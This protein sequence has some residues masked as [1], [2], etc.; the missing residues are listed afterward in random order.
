MAAKGIEVKD[1][2]PDCKII[3]GVLDGVKQS[4]ID[5]GVDL[6]VLSML[7]ELWVTKLRYEK[8]K[9]G[10]PVGVTSRKHQSYGQSEFLQEFKYHHVHL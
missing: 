5:S 2:G 1:E 8:S 6:E 4:F 9:D 10:H 3:S 7:R